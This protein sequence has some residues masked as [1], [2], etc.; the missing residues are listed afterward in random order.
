[1]VDPGG[2]TV[3]G[4]M[5]AI[6]VGG[7]EEQGALTLSEGG[8][9]DSPNVR[10]SERKNSLRSTSARGRRAKSGP[11]SPMM[12]MA[13][14]R[15]GGLR[16]RALRH[17]GLKEMD[18]SD[19]KSSKGK[20]GRAGRGLNMLMIIPECGDAD[21]G[22]MEGLGL[23]GSESGIEG[24]HD[25]AVVALAGEVEGRLV[26][27]ESRLADEVFD[28]FPQGVGGDDGNMLPVKEAKVVRECD[29]E[30]T[31]LVTESMVSMAEM[32]NALDLCEAQ[33]LQ[34]MDFL[35][36]K[37]SMEVSKNTEMLES[38]EDGDKGVKLQEVNLQD[39]LMGGM[40]SNEDF[41]P[42]NKILHSRLRTRRSHPQLNK[43]ERANKGQES[44][45]LGH[46]VEADPLLLCSVAA[47]PQCYNRTPR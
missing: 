39:H 3:H 1:M 22:P 31:N 30:I 7:V 42:L 4:V 35:L 12:R 11:K 13:E 15:K 9:L 6:S 5:E 37:E 27:V 23:E 2:M 36:P 16:G 24:A 40:F 20:K 45:S 44:P 17:L 28:D 38:G 33:P 8:E 26:N 34:N 25:G 10:R 46:L 18:G 21:G 29:E 14:M 41:P 47:A 32:D 43:R 19:L